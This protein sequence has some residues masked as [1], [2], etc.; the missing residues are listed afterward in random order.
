[1]SHSSL[2][3]PFIAVIVS[4]CI[5]RTASVRTRPEGCD[6]QVV[7]ETLVAHGLAAAPLTSLGPAATK[8]HFLNKVT[9]FVNRV[10]IVSVHMCE[11]NLNAFGLH[12][13]QI[14]E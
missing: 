10:A 4:L 7:V 8:R 1:M 13:F 9:F 3:T 5:G 6:A 11:H 12:S 2:V 14:W